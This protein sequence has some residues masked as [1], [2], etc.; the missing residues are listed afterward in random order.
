M[1]KKAQLAVLLLGLFLSSL[2][3]ACGDTP[4]AS[5]IVSA[6]PAT[7]ARVTTAAPSAT[8][9]APATTASV[10]TTNAATTS[11]ATTATGELTVYAAASL[12][13]AFNEIKG[14]IERVNPGLKITYSFAGSN[15]LRTQLEQGAKADVFASADQVQMDNALKSGLVADKGTEFVRNRLVVI[16]SKNNSAKIEKL[17][18]LA[19]PGV[20]FVTAQKDVPV[21]NYTIQALEKM[22]KD[23]TFGSDYQSKVE[24][25][26]VSREANVRQ[27]VSKVQLGEADAA[28]VYLSDVTPKIA[29]ELQTF[30]IPDAF[31]TI[32]SYPIA[33]LKAAANPAGAKVFVDYVLGE[34]GQAILKKNNFVPVKG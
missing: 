22:S 12:T 2:L 1:R 31:N 19:K 24:A 8:T 13:D 28:V 9:A 4:T 14:E 15:A 16:V 3:A 32:A 25:N 10:V 20:K 5:T 21:G 17:Q 6:A 33:P 27:V 11:A 18:D 34:K 30:D 23:A 26:I 7:T 29:P